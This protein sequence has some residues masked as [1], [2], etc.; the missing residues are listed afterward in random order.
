MG[1][2]VVHFEII[3]GDPIQLRTYY[4]ELFEWTFQENSPVAPEVSEID[5][6]SFINRMTTADGTGIPG[7]VGGGHGF[8]SHAIFYVGV[9]DV[10]AA[11]QRLLRVLAAGGEMSCGQLA[12][13]VDIT[14]STSSHHISELMDC[15]LLQMRKDGRFHMLS[16]RRDVLA[17][18]APAILADR[19][20]P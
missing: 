17:K 9:P 5:N 10:E 1:Q 8:R 15:G 16:V 3:G 13:V 20:D 7:G 12:Q 4:A 6:Y 2:P 11:L 18:F 14:A 19:Q